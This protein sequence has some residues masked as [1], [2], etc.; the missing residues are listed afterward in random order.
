MK[1]TGG[2]VQYR[3]LWQHLDELA[4]TR[5]VQWVIIKPDNRPAELDKLDPSLREAVE[6]ARRMKQPPPEPAFKG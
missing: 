6:A 1:K 5:K 4:Q 2:E 3:N